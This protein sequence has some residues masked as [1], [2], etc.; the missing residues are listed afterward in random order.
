MGN[1]AKRCLKGRRLEGSH[2]LLT[3]WSAPSRTLVY[4]SRRLHAEI[5]A[6]RAGSAPG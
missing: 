2:A 3:V 5:P 6:T 4:G 1:V